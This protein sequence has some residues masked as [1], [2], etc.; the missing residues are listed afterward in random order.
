MW[1]ADVAVG[2]SV[3]P[4]VVFPGVPS[5]VTFYIIQCI[6]IALTCGQFGLVNHYNCQLFTSA[7]TNA[8]A[9]VTGRIVTTSAV[10]MPASRSVTDP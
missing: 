2:N 1:S 3:P 7:V 8:I 10:A 4:I 9:P 5:A 6:C